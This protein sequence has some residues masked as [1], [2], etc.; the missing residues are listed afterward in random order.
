MLVAVVGAE[1]GP[2]G[3]VKVLS[4]L[5]SRFDDAEAQTLELLAGSVGSLIH[6]R[7][8]MERLSASEAQFRQL[9]ENV[10]EVFHLTDLGQ[11]RIMY[12]G[13]AHERIRGRTRASLYAAARSW[14]DAV[15]PDDQERVRQAALTWAT[16]GGYHQEY[17]I[18]RPD[19]SMRW[20]RDRTFPVRDG[21][22]VIYRVAGLAEDITER[23]LGADLLAEQAALL[24]KARDAI[25]VRDPDGQ[26]LTILAIGTDI[27][28]KQALEQHFLRAQRLES[29]ATLAGGI[30]HDL[31]K[32]LAPITMAIGLLRISIADPRDLELLDTMADSARRGAGMV[33]Q[34]LQFARGLDGRQGEVQPGQLIQE[35]ETLLRD[36]FPKHVAVL[37]RSRRRTSSSVWRR[38]RRMR[39]AGPGRTSRLPS[40]TPGPVSRR[41]SCAGR[42]TPFLPPRQRAKGRGS[43]FPPLSPSSSAMAASRGGARTGSGSA[44]PGLLPGY[45]PEEGPGN[46]A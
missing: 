18:L 24:D 14:L 33:R 31:N 29:I 7:Q 6:I 40:R 9:A 32:V 20:I 22:G 3:V 1:G 16:T 21:D 11:E 38:P 45:R 4:P 23:K 8:G 28:E 41:S 39:G 5:P 42:S 19:G 25:H 44:I 15:H 12:V 34:V 27:T 13:P 26:P 43:V 37:T 36:M 10:E 30:A 46:G 17:R 2:L 35:I